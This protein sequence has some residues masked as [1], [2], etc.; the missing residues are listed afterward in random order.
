MQIEVFC[1]CDA[2]TDHFGKLNILGA[3]D[4]IGVHKVPTTHYKC[5]IVLRIRFMA[6]EIGRHRVVVN[7]IDADGKHV[8][9]P[10]DGSLNVEA[11]G[12]ANLI[13]NIQGLPIEKFGECSIDLIIDGENCA[14]V[15]LL[16]KEIV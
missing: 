14:S 9:P 2:A 1:L 10:A 15:P 3:F 8:V 6:A 7:F 11:A 4:T 5:A 16:I 13:L 12:S